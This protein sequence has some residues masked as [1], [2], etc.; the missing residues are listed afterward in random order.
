MNFEFQIDN[1]IGLLKET[2]TGTICPNSITEANE[3]IMQHP[4]FR[5][6][7]N[8]ITDLSNAKI[9]FGYEEMFKHVLSIPS[10]QI[11]QQAFIVGGNREYGMIR[12]FLALAEN[13]GIFSKGEVFSSMEEGLQWLTS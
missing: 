6:G 8:F 2:F 4:D 13:K 10:L 5:N 1:S 9:P 11:N 7:L 12:M 3:A